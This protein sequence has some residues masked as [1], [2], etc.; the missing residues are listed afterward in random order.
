MATNLTLDDALI[1]EAVEIGG[2]RTRRAAVNAALEEY[3]KTR[4][5]LGILEWMGRVDYY[6]DYDYKNLRRGRP[7]TLVLGSS[8]D[9]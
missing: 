2:H 7:S 4:R 5:R 6:E 1:A 3:V 9:A 8:A